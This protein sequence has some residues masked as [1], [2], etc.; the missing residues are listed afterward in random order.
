MITLKTRSNEELI[1]VTQK[2]NCGNSIF[3]TTA[4]VLKK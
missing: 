1:G 2:S 3:N 4:N